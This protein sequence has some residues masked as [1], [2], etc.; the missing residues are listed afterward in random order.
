MGSYKDFGI[1]IY[2]I[3]NLN[4][5]VLKSKYFTGGGQSMKF[6][7]RDPNLMILADGVMGVKIMNLTD[8]SAP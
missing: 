3:T 7:T 4:D 1:F 5:P 8:T 6:L 2:D